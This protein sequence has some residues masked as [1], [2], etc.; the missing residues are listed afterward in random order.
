[1]PSS[2]S[3][4]FPLSTSFPSAKRIRYGLPVVEDLV[5]TTSMKSFAV[6]IEV[7]FVSHLP[8][9]NFAAVAAS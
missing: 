3:R 6:L 2:S 7:R 8:R 9:R 1:L 5:A 4:Y